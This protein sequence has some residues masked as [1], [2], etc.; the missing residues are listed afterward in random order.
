MRWSENGL[1]LTNGG[2]YLIPYCQLIRWYTDQAFRIDKFYLLFRRFVNAA[3]KLL[4]RQGWEEE[5]VSQFTESLTKQGGPLCP[6]DVKVPDGITYHLADVYLEELERAATNTVNQDNAS[7]LSKEIP[8]LVLVQ[9]FVTTM[10]TCHSPLVYD[11]IANEVVNPLLKDC[12]AL[13]EKE[14]S[15]SGRKR[16]ATSQ[17]KSRKRGKG[18]L[19]ISEDEDSDE[20]EVSICQFANMLEQ[21]RMSGADLRKSIFEN[22]F[23]TASRSDSIDA[24]RRRL[25]KMC[26]DEEDRLEDEE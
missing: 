21:T 11:R 24:R 13:Q 25:Y 20:D 18:D 9:P 14:K 15:Q 4:A 19:T 12:L 1:V 5:D 6:N 2:V 26:K 7:E 8:L 10:A 17:K 16:K 22:I 3:F 23:Q